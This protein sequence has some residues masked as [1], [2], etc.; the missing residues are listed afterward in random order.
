[1]D[2]SAHNAKDQASH[3]RRTH[4]LITEAGSFLGSSL[5]D[6][7]L[8]QNCAVFGLGNSPLLSDLLVRDNFTLLELDL[9]QPIPAHLPRFDLIFYLDLLRNKAQDQSLSRPSL[10]PTLATV[11]SYAKENN[12]KVFI[13]APILTDSRLMESLFL[14]G[15]QKE[16]LKLLMIGDL[17]GPKMPLSDETQSSQG[18]LSNLISQALLGDKVI[19]EHEG[20]KM[21]Y[22]TFITDAVFAINKFVFKSDGQ[23]PEVIVSESPQSALSVA[24]EIQNVANINFGKTLDLFFA[25]PKPQTSYQPEASLKIGEPSFTPKVKLTQG[26]KETFEY[27]SKVGLLKKTSNG[28]AESERA[29]SP[30]TAL[31][32]K[33]SLNHQQSQVAR[34]FNL[35]LPSTLFKA[36]AK[37]A[38]VVLL[39]ILVFS[40]IKTGLDVYLGVKNLRSAQDALFVGD[41]MASKE[42]AK[43]ASSSFRAAASKSKII[44]LPLLPL[45]KDKIASFNI[46]LSSA[47]VAS[48]AFVH[49]VDGSEILVRNYSTIASPDKKDGIDL[50][51]PQADFKRAY[52]L[53]SQALGMIQTEKTAGFLADKIETLQ[54]SFDQLNKFSSLMLDLTNLTSD[55]VGTDSVSYLLLLQNNTELRPG[56]GFIGNFALADFE[57]GRLKNISVEDIYTIDGQLKEKIEPPKELKDKLK[58][59]RLYLRDSNWSTDFTLNSATARDLFKKETGK[60]VAGV[61]AL[62]LSF[63]QDVL[64][65]TGPIRLDDYNEEISSENLFERGEFHSEVGFFP[66]ST[67]KRDFFSA[68]TRALLAK[69]ITFEENTPWLGLVEAVRDGLNKKHLM[70]VFDNPELASFARTHGW[71][72]PLPPANFNPADDTNET[73]DFLALS[74]ANLGANKANRFL[75]RK[76]A[77]EMT[78]G[79]DADLVAKLTIKYTNNSQAETW[80][81]GKY[82]NF[83]RVYLPFAVSLVEYRNGENT[84]LEQVEVTT[85]G[86][87]TTLATYVEVPIKS[88][89]EVVFTYR[90]PKNIKLEDAPVYHLYVQKQ[91]G[92]SKD[93]FQFTFNL[94]NYLAEKDTGK[95]NL[96]IATDL[97]TDRE[98]KIELV[99]R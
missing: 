50:E 98:F 64:A 13:C 14:E 90:I 1:M 63:I 32:N 95:Q 39:V 77:Y 65:K 93:P 37:T 81:A 94:P 49:F 78:I 92:T 70:I 45:F 46:A 5:I 17:Y 16:L 99:K 43:G 23:N 19:L 41:F 36:R 61:I 71:D 28:V 29:L 48:G 88:S 27:F 97:A 42:K 20:L 2:A 22:P 38:V 76:I 7:F 69:I 8:L 57:G 67:Q 31:L 87:L 79:R 82:I 18:E 15:S 30:K 26:L 75:E 74:E 62:D 4:L 56:G 35:R 54:N 83:L 25:G 33:I 51:S 3:L 73:R 72:H 34:T 47:S 59:D 96:T 10:P 60:N 58:L 6:T 86:S 84:D 40:I 53:S 24:Y 89:K 52:F 66:G 68:L 21:I 55:L 85:Q 11:I 44:T 91:P 9:A 12:S 80:P